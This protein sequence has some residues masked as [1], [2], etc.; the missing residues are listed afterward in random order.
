MRNKDIILNG[1]ICRL[2]SV[3][4]HRSTK[5]L[6]LCMAIFHSATL[7]LTIT[8]QAWRV[9]NSLNAKSSNWVAGLEFPL[10]DIG[11]FVSPV[12]RIIQN[13]LQ[14]HA[15]FLYTTFKYI[16]ENEHNIIF[17]LPCGIE[18]NIVMVLSK[19]W[20]QL[21]GWKEFISRLRT[22]ACCLSVLRP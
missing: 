3:A 5:A 2:T 18:Q 11:T 14:V 12:F 1:L 22:A 10:I 9:N 20:S 4:P 21:F 6:C 16:M 13:I 15:L 8:L 17:A 19:L 7:D